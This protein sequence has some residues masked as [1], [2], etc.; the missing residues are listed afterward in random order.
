[1]T[2]GA[3]GCLSRI[4]VMRRWLSI[5]L[6]ALLPLQ[7]SWA[8][9]SGYC[10]HETGAAAQHF[11]HHEHQHQANAKVQADKGGKTLSAS[12][13]DCSICHAASCPMALQASASVPL[14][15]VAADMHNGEPARLSSALSALPERPN[16]SLA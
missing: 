16:W 15:H 1:M 8:A 9:V 7:L 11:G 2:I 6:L 12:D 4:P 13:V 14:L 10:Q 5:L 3:K